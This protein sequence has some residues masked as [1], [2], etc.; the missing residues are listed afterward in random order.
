[1]YAVEV[2][3]AIMIAHSLPDPF[4]GPAANKHGATFVVDVAFMR[5]ALTAQNVVVDIG[6]AQTALK[7][8]LGP[9]N[10]QDLDALAQFAGRLTTTEFLCRHIFD[11]LCQA[12]GRG[13]LGIGAEALAAMRVTLSE[14][15]LAKAWFEGPV[16]A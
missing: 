12:I 3:D 7:A 5:A 14:T 16:K 15:H 1:M 11:E 9:L 10:Y 8:V 13:E 4:F 6:A 2:R